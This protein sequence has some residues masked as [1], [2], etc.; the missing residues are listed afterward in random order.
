MAAKKRAAILKWDPRWIK[1]PPPPF[2][3]DLGKVA[4][5]QIAEAK[6]TFATRVKA[7]LKRAQ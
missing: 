2:F 4:V 6:S 5:R 7:I 1:D 3:R